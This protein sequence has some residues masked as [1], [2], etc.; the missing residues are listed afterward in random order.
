MSIYQPL[1][2]NKFRLLTL[3]S[4]K[5]G[6]LVRCRLQTE[7]LFSEASFSVP[8]YEA[9]SYTWADPHV[10][11]NALTNEGDLSRKHAIIL[12]GLE[13]TVSHNLYAAL[14]HI[15]F[16]DRSRLLWVDALCIDQSNLT[17]RSL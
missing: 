6:T 16:E 2:E 14:Q 7:L 10:T 15:R 4:G 3:L 8:S 11:Q 9:L 12:N 17:E 1:A 13:F 5:I